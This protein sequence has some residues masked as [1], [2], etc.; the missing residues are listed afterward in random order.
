M[1]TGPD[2]WRSALS[3]ETVD[4][5]ATTEQREAL[6]NNDEIQLGRADDLALATAIMASLAEQKDD[7]SLNTTAS[8]ASSEH[9]A[10]PPLSSDSHE[11]SVTPATVSQEH[12]DSSRKANQKLRHWLGNHGFDIIPNSGSGSN[13]LL[14]S[15]MQHAK[16]N[17]DTEHEAEVNEL[18]QKVKEF[19]QKH[20]PDNPSINDYSLYSD[21]EVTNLLVEKINKGIRHPEDKLSFWFVTAH[22]V[23]GNPFW[24]QV[25]DGPKMAIIFDQGGHYEAVIPRSVKKV[26]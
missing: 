10:S 2:D 26:W 8:P 1:R 14:I 20:Y 11:D 4:K 19:T 3:R 24:R 25:G 9:K 18:R 17:Y 6:R 13:C 16:A 21:D 7:S 22:D 5:F 12:L 23:D 15:M